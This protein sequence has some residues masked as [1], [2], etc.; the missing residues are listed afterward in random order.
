MNLSTH[1]HVLTDGK[2]TM[3]TPLQ[4]FPYRMDGKLYRLQVHCV[5]VLTYLLQSRALTI[6]HCNLCHSLSMVARNHP[7][8]YVANYG[9]ILCVTVTTICMLVDMVSLMLTIYA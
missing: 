4:S 7:R 5:S 9:F 3:G 1:T 6:I 8:S 2:Q